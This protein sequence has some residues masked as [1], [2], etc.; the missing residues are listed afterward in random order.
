MSIQLGPA[1]GI[2]QEIWPAGLLLWMPLSHLLQKKTPK[3][4]TLSTRVLP[5]GH[6]L[7]SRGFCSLDAD[8]SWPWCHAIWLQCSKERFWKL[9]FRSALIW[10]DGA[11][12]EVWSA[13]SLH[14]YC[15]TGCEW[16]WMKYIKCSLAATCAAQLTSH[17]AFRRD[18]ADPDCVSFYHFAAATSWPSGVITM[19]QLHLKC[20]RVLVLLPFMVTI[21]NTF[22]VYS[23]E[24]KHKRLIKI[25][26][27]NMEK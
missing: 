25:K 9:P 21:P 5:D 23:T 13:N 8:V 15:W 19:R 16:K 3:N 1:T 12:Q 22:K 4:K 10:L 2:F 24:M 18:W 17:W 11:Q 7:K 27:N 26:Q 14:T 20:M 6:Y